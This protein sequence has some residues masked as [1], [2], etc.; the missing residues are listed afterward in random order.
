MRRRHPDASG[1]GAAPLAGATDRTVAG[2]GVRAVTVMAEPEEGKP[3]VWPVCPQVG[4]VLAWDLRRK[5]VPASERWP[6]PQRGF[7]R[8]LRL[9]LAR[10]H[11]RPD[12]LA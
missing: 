10:G 6:P 1:A 12:H 8:G 4:Q 7:L 3:A 9:P 2:G 5:V 11:P